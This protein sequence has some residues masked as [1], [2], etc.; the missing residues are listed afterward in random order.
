MGIHG[1]GR[2]AA[3][4]KYT[5]LFSYMRDHVKPIKEGLE[6]LKVEEGKAKRAYEAAQGRTTLQLK[7]FEYA[8]EQMFNFEK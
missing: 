7:K 4:E 1:N 2:R 8:N 6:K 3:H 5:N